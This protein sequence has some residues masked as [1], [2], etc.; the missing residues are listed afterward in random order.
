MDW[1][2]KLEFFFRELKRHDG[3]NYCYAR[4][5]DSV[6]GS[7][8]VINIYIDIDKHQVLT[9]FQYYSQ[10]SKEEVFKVSGSDYVIVN[11]VEEFLV[12]LDE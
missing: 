6:G 7:T 1:R 12:Q 4:C 8:G 2:D 10:E 11:R 5:Y 9:V 3:K